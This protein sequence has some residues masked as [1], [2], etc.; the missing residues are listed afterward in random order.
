MGCQCISADTPDT[1]VR[2]GMREALGTLE[3]PAYFDRLVAA[4]RT[5]GKAI[6]LAESA[7]RAQ[8]LGFGD[9]VAQRRDAA[10]RAR[11]MAIRGYSALREYVH[12][13]R[14]S[15]DWQN[16]VGQLEAREHRTPTAELLDDLLGEVRGY[17][18]DSELKAVSAEE[19][20]E[21]WTRMVERGKQ[22]LVA[23]VDQMIDSL[24]QAGEILSRDSFGRE[25]ASPDEAGYIACTAAAVATLIAATTACGFI[26]FCWCCLF[27]ALLAGFLW[28]I[29]EC[30]R[31]A[32]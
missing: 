32:R 19:Q 8:V 30:N 3:L 24:D 5:A 21:L 10:E 13:R 20:I 6:H 29:G 23:C 12:E 31:I 22:G 25:P 11:R 16:R 15:D 2:D 28:W 18:L 7:D 1:E 9:L 14:S 17:L 26:P 27:P 4:Q